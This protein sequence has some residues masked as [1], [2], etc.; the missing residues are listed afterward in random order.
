MKPVR[1][2]LSKS[3][4]FEV[5]KR[6]S[7]TCQYCGQSAPN[8]TLNV[9]HIVPVS[10]SGSNDLLNL[11]TSCFDCNSGKSN[12]LI[13]DNSVVVKRIEQSKLL[14]EKREQL[15][16]IAIWQNELTDLADCELNI[17]LEYIK[18]NY[19][20]SL[21]E[22]GCGV[23]KK[24]ITKFG[25]TEALES[26]RISE[27]NYLK[28]LNNDDQIKKFLDYI[29]RI[30]YWRKKE[31]DDPEYAECRKLAYIAFAVWK[32]PNWTNPKELTFKFLNL[33][34]TYSLS[35]QDWKSLINQS[36]NM[37]SLNQVLEDL[38]G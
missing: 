6:D 33:K 26:T 24:I 1:A 9:D 22:H 11:I 28:D 27:L 10:K 25:I 38:Y 30:C 14:S 13:S 16:M 23:F 21:T 34:K 15:E 2:S 20:I 3:L 35:F 37:N 19:S 4:R 12:K 36:K 8:A 7:F 31:K 17:F 32:K 18:D 5:F 29:P